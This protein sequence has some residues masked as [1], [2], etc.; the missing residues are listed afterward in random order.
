[1]KNIITLLHD[2]KIKKFI[3]SV[4]FTALFAQKQVAAKR[5]NIGSACNTI[6]MW[7]DSIRTIT[8]IRI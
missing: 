7:R 8:K 5:K 1:M 4:L 2:D 3:V 6:I